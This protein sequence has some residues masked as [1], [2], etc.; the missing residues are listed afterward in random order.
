MDALKHDDYR[1]LFFLV[2][3]FFDGEEENND[4]IRVVVFNLRGA[5][6]THCD[7][8]HPV[9]D[10]KLEKYQFEIICVD[11][12]MLYD[13]FLFLPGIPQNRKFSKSQNIRKW[14]NWCQH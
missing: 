1:E 6:K 8:T 12:E 7:L 9:F 3:G 2:D 5:K 13:L 11:Q 4:S 14:I 10:P